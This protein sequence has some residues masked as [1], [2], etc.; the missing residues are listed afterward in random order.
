MYSVIHMQEVREAP[1]P[2]HPNKQL[3]LLLRAA[4]RHLEVDS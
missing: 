2:Q 1:L 4:L 3:Q